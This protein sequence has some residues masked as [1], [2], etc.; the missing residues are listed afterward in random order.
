M[1]AFARSAADVAPARA[2][3]R[4]RA[5]AARPA[6]RR[7]GGRDRGRRPAAL[8]GQLR[9]HGR[10]PAR[11]PVVVRGRE[12]D[13]V[14][15]PAARRSC[16]ASPSPGRRTGRTR[17]AASARSLVVRSGGT[18]EHLRMRWSLQAR[19]AVARHRRARVGPAAARAHARPLTQQRGL[20]PLLRQAV[21]HWHQA[22]LFHPPGPGHDGPAPVVCGV[23]VGGAD[24]AEEAVGLVVDPGAEQQRLAV[25]RHAVSEP[26]APEAVD[27]NGVAVRPAELAEP[28][29][30]AGCC[31]R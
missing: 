13:H 21:K 17:P 5:T 1:P 18:V 10:G 20:T 4:D 3:R 29:A 27:L 2:G 6:D 31:R 22:P 24:H 23:L 28:L 25:A 26:Q 30:G 16:R 12:P 8:V 11:R 9:R 7:G 19:A 15:V 14:H